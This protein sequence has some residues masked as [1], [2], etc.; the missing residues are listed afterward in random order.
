L[1][2]T[3]TKADA[4]GD[5]V[6][7]IY[8]W[9]VNGVTVQT[10]ASTTSTTNTYT[11]GTLHKNDV[12]TVTV[13]PN[14]GTLNGAPVSASKTSP[15]NPPS[16]T[17]AI[18]G[19]PTTGSTLTA[20]ASPTDPDGDAVTLIYVWS[21]N[22]TVKQTSASTSSTTNTYT[23]GTIHKGDTIT[24]SVTPNDGT[25]NGAAATASVIGPN[26]P[27]S[28]TVTLSSPLKNGTTAT[29]TATDSDP[30]GDPVTLVY[31]WKVN[32]TTVRTSSSTSSLTDTWA[33]TGTHKGDTV[34]V[35][36]TPNDGTVNGT[37]AT[38]TGTIADTPPTATVSLSP[39]TP[40]VTNTVT[41]TATSADVDGDTVTLSYA[42]SVGGTT[43]A[44]ATGPTLNLAT[45]SGAHKGQA[46][47]VTV[48]PNDG[49]LNG[50]PATASVTI[51]DSPPVVDSVTITP[52]SPT[53]T[54]VVTA[55]VTG[56]DPDGDSI[57]YSYQWT[58]N[59]SSIS[60]A[61]SST[62][63]LAT[64]GV[65]VGSVISVKVTP[66]DGTIS[67]A[68]V[69]AASSVTV[70]NA[71]E[72][73]AYT[74]GTTAIYSQSMTLSNTL[75]PAVTGA[76]V[77]Y[78]WPTGGGGSAGSVGGPAN[79]SVGYAP[80]WIGPKVVTTSYAGDATHS[81]SSTTAT[82]TVSAPSVISVSGSPN[83]STPGQSV[84]ID[85]HLTENGTT[86]P[87]GTSVVFKDG[88]TTIGTV[89]I[90]G[91]GDA[92]LNTTSLA[93]GTHTITASYAGSSSAYILASSATYTQTVAAPAAI[94]I[95]GS[96]EGALK[97]HPG[98][99]VYGGFDFTAP[100]SHPAETVSFAG[101]TVTIIGTCS[102][103]QTDNLGTIA[104]PAYTLALAASD[105]NWY[106]SGDQSSSAVLQGSI[107]APSN[108]CGGGSAYLNAPSGA[109]FST[110]VSSTDTTDPV[111]VRFHYKTTGSGSWSGTSSVVP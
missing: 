24:V 37:P 95:S 69:S 88:S 94:S 7:L 38:A 29:A 75:T 31:V 9:T 25:L 53:T 65:S 85:A 91:S 32:G 99:T 73:V 30:D 63:N 41:A 42:W 68:T 108:L 93:T 109:T 46:V 102:N 96:M 105:S 76:N 20:T 72:T 11:A 71:A 2:A 56:H 14:D 45:V 16:T 80:N 57:T 36:V 77:T 86:F 22:G 21:V 28:A 60:G 78:S 8:V 58:K 23:L 33:V 103:G 89:A 44:G 111:N 12:V 19:T 66:S 61:T 15:D 101:G 82:V 3:A 54:S 1:T 48:T 107:Q 97:I 52:A 4:D 100:G 74:G 40:N 34:T 6:H 51:A 79:G 27:P 55:N 59:G 5:T 18:T 70:A 43:V 67:G 98:D 50:T 81:A 47:Q 104:I 62:L 39:S 110:S 13:T 17:V 64:A 35:S 106:P 26:N 49:T 83:S 92:I 90:N 87:A 84:A 10:S